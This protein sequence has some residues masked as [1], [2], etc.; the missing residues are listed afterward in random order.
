MS[1]GSHVG[2]YLMLKLVLKVSLSSHALA[3]LTRV[4]GL[5]GCLRQRREDPALSCC[6]R[7]LVRYIHTHFI[8]I[9]HIFID[10]YNTAEEFRFP[11][12]GSTRRSL[13]PRGEIPDGA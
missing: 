4:E 11:Y 8:A 1:P 5:K 13:F 10:T 12:E 7:P 3:S 6:K 9:Q 2:S